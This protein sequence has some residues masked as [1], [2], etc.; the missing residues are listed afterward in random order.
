MATRKGTKATKYTRK[1]STDKRTRRSVGKKATAKK[2][3]P[4]KGKSSASKAASPRTGMAS[5]R[6]ARKPATPRRRGGQ[7]PLTVL[8]RRAARLSKLVKEREAKAQGSL[9]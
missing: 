9:F 6:K 4:K 8:K 3:S 1:A 7:I 2:K 5:V